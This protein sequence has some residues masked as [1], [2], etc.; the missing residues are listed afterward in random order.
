[1]DRIK[2]EEQNLT[3]N[4]IFNR[5]PVRPLKDGRDVTNRGSPGD[6]EQLSSYGWTPTGR[7]KRRELQ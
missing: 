5:G 6:G 7:P 2:G 3:I 1:M 4:T